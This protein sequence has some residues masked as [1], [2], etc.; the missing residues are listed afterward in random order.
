[1]EVNK[2]NKSEGSWIISD[3]K[4][5][6]ILEVTN[7][8]CGCM[9]AIYFRRAEIYGVLSVL[10]LL[11]TYYEYFMIKWDSDT[12]YY[13]DN[14]EVISTLQTLLINPNF[15][16]EKYKTCDHYALL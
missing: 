16:D 10:T 12:T 5:I 7:L 15:Y 2:K 4:G 13:C 14:S 3:G 6:T 1:M 9:I 8:D 11:K